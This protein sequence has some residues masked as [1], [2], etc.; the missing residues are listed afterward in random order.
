MFITPGYPSLKRNFLYSLFLFPLGW[1]L[2]ALVT[3]LVLR[4]PVRELLWPYVLLCVLTV[5]LSPWSYWTEKQAVLLCN[6]RYILLKMLP[7]Y[8]IGWGF[9]TF[10]AVSRRVMPL[11]WCIGFGTLFFLVPLIIFYFK[12]PQ[13]TYRLL[14]QR[15]ASL[16]AGT[17][18][19]GHQ[20]NPQIIP[21]RG[22]RE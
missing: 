16:D 9:F 10:F 18:D 13:Q 4:V 19:H 14:A 2:P 8:I 6:P 7:L 21:D 20:T 1:L 12:P 22:K 11:I 17:G 3:H 15:K 5:A